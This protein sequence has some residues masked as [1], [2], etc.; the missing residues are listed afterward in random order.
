MLND[1]CEHVYVVGHI[2]NGETRDVHMAR[3]RFFANRHLQVDRPL[4]NA[5]QHSENQGEQYIRGIADAKKTTY[6]DEYM[7]R[8]E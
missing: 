6:R 8:V 2:V 3:M 4:Q 7:V 5:F 1:H